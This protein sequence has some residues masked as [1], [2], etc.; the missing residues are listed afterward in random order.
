MLMSNHTHTYIYMIVCVCVCVCVCVNVCVCTNQ[1]I[2]RV[3]DYMDIY[4]TIF[5]K[6]YVVCL[7]FIIRGWLLGVIKS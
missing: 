1:Q 4:I 3:I 6:F 5:L 2:L 7:I